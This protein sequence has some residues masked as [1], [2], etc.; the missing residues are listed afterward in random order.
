MDGGPS[1]G[2][3]SRMAMCYFVGLFRV[4]HKRHGMLDLNTARI[5]LLKG[6]CWQMN[7]V[8]GIRR[9][10]LLGKRI[11]VFGTLIVLTY[12]CLMIAFRSGELVAHWGDIIGVVIFYAIWPLFIGGF[13]WLIAW[14]L[15][16]FLP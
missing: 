16:G 10:R 2:A 12:W 8:E 13:L 9:I 15:E 1:T 4:Q 5:Q 3:C 14:I 6:A 11:M 7:T